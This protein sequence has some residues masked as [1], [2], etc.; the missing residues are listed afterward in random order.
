MHTDDTKLIAGENYL[1]RLSLTSMQL[2]SFGVGPPPPTHTHSPLPS[3]RF[4][5]V[6]AV[7][8][9]RAAHCKHCF[10]T[11]PQM[12]VNSKSTSSRASP[13]PRS[14][15]VSFSF[16]FFFFHEARGIEFQGVWDA[17]G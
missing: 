2:R 14:H 12:V 13:Q 16:F 8:S 1:Q 9:I 4:S 11:F 3:S 7:R 6:R 5:G 10:R 15:R 17:R